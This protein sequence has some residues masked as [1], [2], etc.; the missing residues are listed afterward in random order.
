[1]TGSLTLCPTASSPGN[2]DRMPVRVRLSGSVSCLHRDRSDEKQRLTVKF[3]MA[4]SEAIFKDLNRFGMG[5]SNSPRQLLRMRAEHPNILVP[6]SSWIEQ[7]EQIRAKLESPNAF[8]I[9]PSVHADSYI[10]TVPTVAEHKLACW[11]G[12]QN[13]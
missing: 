13:N 12:N 5:Q 2:P 11:T 10:D 3:L 4:W 8:C 7:V 9:H 1:M 6:E